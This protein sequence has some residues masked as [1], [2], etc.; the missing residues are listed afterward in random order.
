M[1][2]TTRDSEGHTFASMEAAIAETQEHNKNLDE[3]QKELLRWHHK[4]CH[5][6]MAHTQWI[7]KNNKVPCKNPKAIEAI[8]KLPMC[9]ACCFAK[10]HKLPTGLTVTKPAKTKRWSLRRMT[11][12]QDSKS[13]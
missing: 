1:G 2:V 11:F 7:C 10:G 8:K 4:L 6:N 5:C 9:A 12:T 3:H 13:A